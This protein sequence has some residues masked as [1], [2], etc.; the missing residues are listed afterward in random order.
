MVAQPRIL[1]VLPVTP[2]RIDNSSTCHMKDI[3]K[4]NQSVFIG[5]LTVL[6]LS[7]TYCATALGAISGVCSDCHTMHNRQDNAPM[8]FDNST[9]PNESLTRGDCY[10]CHAQGGSTPTVTV[11][12]SIIPQVLHSSTNHLAGGNF[13]YITGL[14]GSGAADSK[15][16]NIEDLTGSDGVLAVPP[17]DSAHNGLF[18]RGG[19]RCADNNGCHGYRAYASGSYDVNKKCFFC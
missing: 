1:V 19:L 5:A 11:G 4:F 18:I 8:N 12:T 16:H 7:Q 3:R 10:G 14:A 17:G 13:G 6:L 15:G 9:T 2:P